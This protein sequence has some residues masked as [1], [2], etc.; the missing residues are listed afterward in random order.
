MV[1]QSCRRL[2]ACHRQTVS[3][4]ARALLSARWPG[5]APTRWTKRATGWRRSVP[6]STSLPT[7]GW[8]GNSR[9]RSGSGA[10]ISLIASLLNCFFR[11]ICLILAAYASA[12]A[13]ERP[14]AAEVQTHACVPQTIADTHSSYLT[15]VWPQGADAADPEDQRGPAGD[16]GGRGLGARVR[17]EGWG[18]DIIAKN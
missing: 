13:C 10:G 17:E 4:C 6:A 18:G 1:P 12:V 15:F 11:S 8:W 14:G 3:R 5:Q 2:L 7:A 9:A 16:R